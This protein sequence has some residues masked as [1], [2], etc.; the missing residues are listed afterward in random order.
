[1]V[2]AIFI[3]ISLVSCKPKP[4]VE[5]PDIKGTYF[6][7]FQFIQDQFKSYR[8]TPYSFIRTEVLN[9]KKDSTMVNINTIDWGSVL[10]PFVA[11]DIG[12]KRYIGHYK[13]DM[14]EDNTTGTRNF[15]YEAIDDTLLTR[16][17]Q[18]SA[19][20]VSNR[21]VSIYVET[22][23]RTGWGS[24]R[25]Q[26]LFYKPLKYIQIQEYEKKK[27]GADKDLRVEYQFL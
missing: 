22:Q 1:M 15:F 4:K 11:S 25:T 18:I 9:G 20:P 6:S 16:K 13:F 7:V 27:F 2:I 24:E 5:Y 8:G 14:F 23:K 21:I 19:D 12:D 26:K 3:A 10:Q 17:L